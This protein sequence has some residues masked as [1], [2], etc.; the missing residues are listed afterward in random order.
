MRPRMRPSSTRRSMPSKAALAPYVL[1]SPR[2]SMIAMPSALLVAGGAWRKLEQLLRRQ[3][4]PLDGLPDLGP[5]LAQEFLP[6]A[7]QQQLA[8]AGVDEH[9]EAAP[10]LHQ[11]LVDQLLVTLQDRDRIDP[12]LRRDGSHRGQRVAF[13]EHLVENHRDDP[14]SQLA[15]DRLAVVPVTVHQSSRAVS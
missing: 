4:Q 3:P 9:S 10:R 1:R 15:I 5:F 7:A 12:V 13:L 8:G 6:L 14:V 11:A 2:A